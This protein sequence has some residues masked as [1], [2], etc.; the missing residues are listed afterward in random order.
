MRRKDREVTEP[1]ALLEIIRECKICRIAMQD[2]QGLYI[3]PLNFGY[4]FDDGKLTLYFHSAK[5]GRKID[6]LSKAPIVAFEMDCSH[7]LIESEI[8]CRNGYAYKS[9][10]GNG[11]ASLIDDI[12]EKIKGLSLI[13][14]HQTGKEFEM[15]PQA[16][17]SVAVFKIQATDFTGKSR[18]IPTV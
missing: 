2:E 8:A 1:A 13:M 3:V 5:E 7:Q 15:P 11:S 14:N 18:P 10:I 16:A 9:I 6:I 4:E 12:E 17:N